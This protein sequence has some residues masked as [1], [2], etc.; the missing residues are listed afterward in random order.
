MRK[1]SL[2]CQKC[3]VEI[4]VNFNMVMIKDKLWF[5]YFKQ[6]DVFCDSC[7]EEKI[8][9]KITNDDLKLCEDGSEIPANM[10]WKEEHLNKKYE[11][12]N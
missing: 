10:F 11:K 3:K 9:R 12:N 1:K 7:I 8:G 2:Y 4:F 5:K 6:S